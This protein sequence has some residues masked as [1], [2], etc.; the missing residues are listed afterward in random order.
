MDNWKLTYEDYIKEEEPRREALCTLGNGYFGTRGAAEESYASQ[1]HYPGTYLAGG[2]NRLKTSIAGQTIENEDFVN[3]PNWL[4]LSFKPDKG[5]WLD[6][7]KVKIHEYGQTLNLEEGVLERN[8][9]FEDFDKRKTR[10]TSRRIVSMH[11]PHL[12]AIEWTLTPINWSEQIIIRSGL[13]GTVLNNGVE[14]YSELEGQHLEPLETQSVGDRAISLLVRTTQS[15]VS[16][17]QAA[18]TEVY[19]ST[20]NLPVSRSVNSREGYI[21]QEIVVDVTEGKSIRIEKLIALYTSRDHA[22]SEPLWE[23]QKMMSEQF[24]FQALYK[25]HANVWK[26]LWHRCNVDLVTD[27]GRDQLLIR[28]HIFHLM[29]TTSQHIIDLDVGVPPRG[30]TGEAYRGHILWDEIFIFPFL[31]LSIPEITRALLMYRYRRLGEARSY[32]KK[33]GYRGAM[34]PWQSGSNG[35][36]ESQVIHL[37]PNSGN[38][39]PDN[40]HL[41]RHVN[42]AIAYNVWRYYQSTGDHEFLSFYGAEMLLEIARFWSSISHYNRDRDKYEIHGVVGPDEYHTQYPDSEEAGLKNNAYTNVMAVYCIYHALVTLDILDEHRCKELKHSLGL[43]DEDIKEWKEIMSRMYIPFQRDGVIIDQFEGFEDLKELDWDKYH[44]AYGDVLRLDRIL[45]G[46]GDT[47]NRYKAIKQADVLMLFYL[48]SSEELDKLF[49]LMGYD[50]DKNIIPKNIDYYRNR[51]SHGSTLSKL[52]MSWIEAREDRESSWQTF[53]NA[54]VSDFEDIQGSTTPEGIHLGAMA[55]TVDMIHRCYTGLETRDDTLFFNPRLPDNLVQIN[56][57]LRYRGHWLLVDL[58]QEDIYIKSDGGWNNF[59]KINVLG[60][61]FSF[62]KRG[63]H[64]VNYRKRK[65]QQVQEG[66]KKRKKEKV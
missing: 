60:R 44:K 14:R 35:R 52:V 15:R 49:S 17:A 40:T 62:D 28:L 7:D 29:Q 21:E 39:I 63:E 4:V 51:S 38:W 9:L 33:K 2:Y 56:L 64:R 13:D 8:V 31:N 59:I 16:M 53:S 34:Y 66:K 27:E 5:H 41:Q 36:E 43:D 55:G 30:L 26:M 54:L 11:N 24:D 42:A 65:E 18:R 45:E 22:I 23:A 50:F 19:N 46:E 12:A 3:W 61:E 48:F 25:Q 6:L 37:N 20:D 57:R 1:V 47:P 10:L 58:G 32:A